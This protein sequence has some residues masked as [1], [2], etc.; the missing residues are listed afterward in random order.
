MKRGSTS[1]A[2]TMSRNKSK[3]HKERTNIQ[4]QDYAQKQKGGTQ[5]EDQ[6][7]K[8]RQRTK[9]KGRNTK[10]GPT[11]K[12]ETTP[13]NKREEHKERINIQSQDDA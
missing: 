2:Q 4:S 10:R 3:E 13:Q 6:H 8:P 5:R 11:S 12:V 7:P 9:T 1:K